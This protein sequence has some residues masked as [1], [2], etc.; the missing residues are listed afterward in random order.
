MRRERLTKKLLWS[1]AEG[2]FIASNCMQADHS[3]IFAETLKPLAER[4]EQWARIRAERLN[5]TLF[6]IFGDVRA[7]EEH[8][9]RKEETRSSL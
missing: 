2:T 8:K 1:L 5:G 3:P 7:F 6:N 9:A 4:E